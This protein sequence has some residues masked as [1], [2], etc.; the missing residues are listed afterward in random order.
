MSFI[1]SPNTATT[2][3]DRDHIVACARSWLRTPY[4]HQA[5]IKGAGT[6][7][8]GL[9]RGV[10]RELYGTEPETPPPYTA[11]WNER[12]FNTNAQGRT[13]TGDGAPAQPWNRFVGSDP[14]LE[15]ATRHLHAR[16]DECLEPG[17]VLIFQIT[18]HGPAKHC[19]IL[20][21][22]DRFVHAYAGRT[23]VE[24]WLNRWWRSRIAGV[25]S[26][27]GSVPWHN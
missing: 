19:G 8:L 14:L 7:C 16:D 5:A 10:W 26:F 13:A 21:A 2:T 25:F 1:Q 24:G 27:P 9:V 20:T 12:H 18:R 22:D 4:Q 15:A 11:D 3:L 6:D 23:V 17:D